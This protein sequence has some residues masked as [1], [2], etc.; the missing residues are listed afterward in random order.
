LLLHEGVMLSAFHI[1]FVLSFAPFDL[2]LKSDEKA[3]LLIFAKL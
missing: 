2:Y 1:F 3:E